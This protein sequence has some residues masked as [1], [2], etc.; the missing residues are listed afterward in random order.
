MLSTR[1]FHVSTLVCRY[2]DSDE[3]ISLVSLYVLCTTPSLFSFLGVGRPFPSGSHVKHARVTVWSA[4]PL[5]PNIPYKVFWCQNVHNSFLSAL[6]ALEDTSL[7]LSPLIS[8]L[9]YYGWGVRL[10]RRMLLRC[11]WAEYRSATCSHFVTCD[12]FKLSS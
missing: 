8:S 10:Q 7:H 1:D 11:P 3:E 2:W 5:M 6:N 9:L 4:R 12:A